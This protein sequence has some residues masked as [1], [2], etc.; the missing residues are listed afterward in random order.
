[1]ESRPGLPRLALLTGYERAATIVADSDISLLVISKEDFDEMMKDDLNDKRKKYEEVL[2]QVQI[3]YDLIGYDKSEVCDSGSERKFKK[4][5]EIFEQDDKSSHFFVVHS[6]TVDL[7]KAVYNEDTDTLSN[8]HL[9]T[10]NPGETFGEYD[11]YHKVPRQFS[12]VASSDVELLAFDKGTFMRILPTIE[13]YL[14]IYI[15]KYE[16]WI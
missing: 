6:G 2:D 1:M 9:T 14:K 4:G 16:P 13:Y 11:L 15:E 7:L 5:A 8:T 12:A 3:F 10:V